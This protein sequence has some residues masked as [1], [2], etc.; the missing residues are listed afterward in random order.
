M[1]VQD[2]WGNYA[3]SFQTGDFI[4]YEMAFDCSFD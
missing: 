2:F 1:R 3:V 4:R